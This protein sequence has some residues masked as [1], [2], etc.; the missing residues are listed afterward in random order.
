MRDRIHKFLFYTF[1]LS[2][3]GVF[4]SIQSFY[5]FE[6]Q[7]NV[8]ATM[9]YT[10][11]VKQTGGHQQFLRAPSPRSSRSIRLNKRFFKTDIE[12]CPVFVVRTPE[13]RIIPRVLGRYRDL[14]LSS[15]QVLH[16]P[17]RGPPVVA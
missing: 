4:F 10:S 2:V 3:Y 11:M 13:C 16:Y 7:L 9:A 15:I 17:L 5:N 12:P 8:K 6:G 1:L 14:P